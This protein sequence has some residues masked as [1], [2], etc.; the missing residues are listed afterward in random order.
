MSVTKPCDAEMQ[1]T[2]QLPWPLRG[3]SHE[4]MG[5]RFSF[6]F[7]P[8]KLRSGDIWW[9]V[10]VRTSISRIRQFK[11][12]FHANIKVRLTCLSFRATWRRGRKK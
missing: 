8:T 6:F 5:L 10:G 9:G 12:L 4:Q 11:P 1:V 2:S 3:F 7:F